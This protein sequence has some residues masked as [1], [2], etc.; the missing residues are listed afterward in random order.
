MGKRKE[1][2]MSGIS[3]KR[4]RILLKHCDRLTA[5]CLG[6]DDGIRDLALAVEL[7]IEV[8]RDSLQAEE[9]GR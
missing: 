9:G 5:G 1:S 8:V 7:L 4:H 6:R 3:S 2:L